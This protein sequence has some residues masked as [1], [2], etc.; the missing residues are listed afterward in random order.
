MEGCSRRDRGAFI[1]S[2]P[3]YRPVRAHR[4]KPE[5]VRRPWDGLSGVRGVIMLGIFVTY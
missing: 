1:K 2:T 4:I 3:F 5:L